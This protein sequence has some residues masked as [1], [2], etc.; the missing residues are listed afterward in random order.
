MHGFKLQWSVNTDGRLMVVP[1]LDFLS[2]VYGVR[3]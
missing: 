2:K 1:D 3:L